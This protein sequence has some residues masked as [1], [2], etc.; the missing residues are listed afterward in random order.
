MNY[1]KRLREDPTTSS[2]KVSV[3]SRERRALYLLNDTNK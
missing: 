1:F 3:D 2:E